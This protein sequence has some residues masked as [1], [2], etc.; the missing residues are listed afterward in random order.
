MCCLSFFFFFVLSNNNS[1]NQRN[2]PRVHKNE[3]RDERQNA[4]ALRPQLAQL[5]A[6]VAEATRLAE[7]VK[8]TVFEWRTRA[9]AEE[10]ERGEIQYSSA[11]KYGGNKNK[12]V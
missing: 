11:A 12:Q 7:A 4:D 10:E 2:Q 9:E 5:S 1:A 6:M 8:D 3:C